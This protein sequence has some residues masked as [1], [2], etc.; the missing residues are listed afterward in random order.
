MTC[1]K[2]LTADELHPANVTR[3]FCK[4]RC[5]QSFCSLTFCDEGLLSHKDKTFDRSEFHQ[6]GE[7]GVFGPL[8]REH[9]WVM[10]ILGDDNILALIFQWVDDPD[11]RKS[12]SLVC[13]QWLMVEGFTR[14]SL[15][16]FEPHLLSTFL[17]RFPN[18]LLFQSSEVISSFYIE[19]VARTCPKLEV[20]DINYKE[21]N[22]DCDE[23]EDNLLGLVDVDD[24]GIC[25]IAMCCSNLSKVF[26]RRR[27]RIGNVG[28]VSLVNLL[29]NLTILD[30]GWCSGITDEALEAIGVAANSLITLNLQGCCLITDVG[31]ASLTKGS[32]S[33][34]LK[35]LV[36]ADCDRIT[37]VGVLHLKQMYCLEQL[38]LEE[39][40][41]KV[42]DTGGMAISEIETLKRLKLSWLM[43][44]TDVTLIALAQNC[45]NL[46]LLDLKGCE[47]VTGNGIRAFMGHEAL[48]MLVLVGCDNVVGDD[49]EQIVLGCRTLRYIAL[50]K[51]LRS[52]IPL[53]MQQKISKS[54]SLDWK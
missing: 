19:F 3:L 13:K 14:L 37:D 43:N 53:T 2:G 25:A 10:E 16:V 6:L 46:V 1:G 42:T 20:L 28:V 50:D 39:C 47:F 40:G 15:R 31:L 41:S 5:R 18:L 38:N 29:H 32:L 11:H 12:F 21:K 45:Q 33:R 54:C 17:P 34:T 24:N 51:R 48:E 23:C 36:I 7:I 49:L 27:S 9:N 35:K 8:P 4:S 44:I 30:L 52:W 22:D 26:L